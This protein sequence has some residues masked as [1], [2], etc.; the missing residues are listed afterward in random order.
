MAIIAPR[1]RTLVYL[2]LPV[3]TTLSAL[4][5]GA[6]ALTSAL[7]IIAKARILQQVLAPAFT[8]R[9]FHGNYKFTLYN[10]H[11][12]QALIITAVPQMPLV[13]IAMP[14]A[15]H[16][17]PFTRNILGLAAQTQQMCLFF[18]QLQMALKSRLQQLRT[19]LHILLRH[20]PPHRQTTIILRPRVG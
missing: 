17:E 6:F 10:F 11:F 20:T 3:V 14:E 19:P 15:Y 7:S 18:R 8:D 4:T 13:V 2:P 12:S 16:V 5:T 9:F 1:R